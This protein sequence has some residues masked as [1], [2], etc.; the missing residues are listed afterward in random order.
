MKTGKIGVFGASGFVGS[1]LCERL[2]FEGN[3]DFICFIRSSGN[4]GRISRLPVHIRT[5]DVL[6]RDEVLSAVA[7]CEI[8]V[9]CILGNNASMLRGIDNLTS[10]ARRTKPKKFIHLSS[11]AIYG[12]DPAPDSVTEE[13]IPNPGDNEYGIV[14]LRQDKAV[15]GLQRMGIPTYILCPGNIT[16]PYSIFSRDLVLRLM[17]GPLPLVDGGRNP[18]NMIHVDNLVEAILAAIGSDGG[19]GERY[20]VNETRPI[21][22]REVFDDFSQRLGFS[23]DYVDVRREQV[24]PFL[25]E[26]RSNGGLKNHMKIALSGE[27]RR[28][29]AIMPVFE[30]LNRF[31]ATSFERFSPAVQNRIKERLKGPIHIEPS[32]NGPRLDERYVKVQARRFCHSPEKLIRNLGWQPPLSYEGGVD[33]IISWLEFAGIVTAAK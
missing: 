19:A 11:I 26:R 13:G 4:A 32:A 18:S 21:S 25:Q 22:W 27:F 14:K 33:T 10:A 28:A 17:S 3:R 8:V 6:D 9:N 30:R 31:A 24:L 5:V 20:F 2:H 15:M 7:D 12:Q 1:T 29:V 16:G 23:C